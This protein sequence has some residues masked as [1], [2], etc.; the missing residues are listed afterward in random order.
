MSTSWLLELIN[1]VHSSLDSSFS[2]MK[3]QWI[4]MYLVHFF[5]KHKIQSNMK[6]CLII[7]IQ[8]HLINFTEFQL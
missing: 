6:G 3:W 7:T 2:M 8:L 1:P 4:S 5:M